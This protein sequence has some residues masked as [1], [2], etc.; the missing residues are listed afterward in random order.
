MYFDKAEKD[1]FSILF[2]FNSASILIKIEIHVDFN[3]Y[4]T[5]IFLFVVNM[6]QVTVVVS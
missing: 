6:L 2:F 5:R 1:I 4:Y 3:W